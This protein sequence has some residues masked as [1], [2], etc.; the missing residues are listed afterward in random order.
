M[1]MVLPSYLLRFGTQVP[2]EAEYHSNGDIKPRY[3][4]TCFCNMAV[5]SALGKTQYWFTTERTV[6]T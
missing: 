1:P 3:K 2:V 5:W 6:P 4:G